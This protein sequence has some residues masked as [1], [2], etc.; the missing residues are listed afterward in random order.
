VIVA[1]I[2]SGPTVK[3]F[4]PYL[5]LLLNEFDVLQYEGA[6]VWD[7]VTHSHIR[8]RATILWTNNDYRGI[9]LINNQRQ[10]SAIGL[11]WS[12]CVLLLASGACDSRQLQ[13]L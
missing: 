5:K 13:R 12:D 3:Q 7:A 2:T 1:G 4:E 10:V 11:N 6:L 8:V 9:P